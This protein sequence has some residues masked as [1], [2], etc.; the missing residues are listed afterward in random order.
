MPAQNSTNLYNTITNKSQP[1]INRCPRW[2]GPTQS[3]IWG[4]SVHFFLLV[5][6]I[7]TILDQ[8]QSGKILSFTGLKSL[9]ESVLHTRIE[10]LLYEIRLIISHGSALWLAPSNES[11][12][13]EGTIWKQNCWCNQEVN[14]RK[15]ISEPNSIKKSSAISSLWLTSNFGI[16]EIERADILSKVGDRMKHTYGLFSVLQSLCSALVCDLWDEIKQL[17]RYFYAAKVIICKL[18]S[19]H[20]CHDILLD[21]IK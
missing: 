9:Q 6:K 7:S 4:C 5:F 20:S 8:N 15:R 19:N 3:L 14:T 10:H 16:S 1:F 21:F 11:Q 18:K 2:I 12:T 17:W 13:M